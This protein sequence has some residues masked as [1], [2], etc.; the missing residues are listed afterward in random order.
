MTSNSLSD[1]ET[2]ILKCRTEESKLYISDAYSAYKAGAYRSCIV[3]TWIA[4]VFDLIDK[5]RELSIAGDKK[6]QAILEKFEKLQERIEKSDPEAIRDSLAFERSI[7]DVAKDELSLIDKQQLIDLERLKE[8]RNRCAHP[9]FQRIETPYHPTP[10]QARYHINNTISYVLK[11]PP[12][13]GKQAL[14]NLSKLVESSY[15]PLD[16]SDA[17]K[18]LQSSDLSRPT[19]SL[20]NAFVD[21]L[22]HSYFD[23]DHTLYFQKRTLV[24]LQCC[25]HMHHSESI[26]RLKS[27]FEKINRTIGDD[28]LLLAVATILYIPELWHEIEEATH[29]RIREYILRCEEDDFVT[30]TKK[31]LENEELKPHILNRISELDSSELSQ[32]I[33]TGVIEE[34]VER[35]VDVFCSAR[36]WR[37]ANQIYVDCIL[38]IIQELTKDHLFRIVRSHNDESSDLPGSTGFSSYLEKTLEIG[39]I[40]KEELVGELNAQDLE[41]IAA[42]FEDPEPEEE[43]AQE[44]AF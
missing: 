4:L 31:G 17:L 41:F 36:N 13:Q 32:L 27:Q 20:I 25:L 2:L 26:S 44:P 6:A 19:E 14:S 42:A 40:S 23:Q 11:M 18:Q 5:I 38:P 8:D 7:L 35:A 28:K 12:V 43:D 30:L 1:I 3:T 16:F 34:C 29:I 21:K 10:E 22:I 33:K 24:A 9:T 39:T 15:F 37:H